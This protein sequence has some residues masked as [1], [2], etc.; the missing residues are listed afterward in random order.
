MAKI[1][2]VK[3]L[4]ILVTLGSLF[5][6]CF[7]KD[8][9]HDGL[10]DEKD[11]CPLIGAKSKNGCPVPKEMDEIHLYLDNSA[12]MGG[13][14]SESTEYK[15][16]VSDLAVTMEKEIKPISISFIADNIIFYPKDAQQFTSD[17]ATTRIADQNSSQLHLMIQK[18]VSNSKANDVSLLISDCILSFPDSAIKANPEINKTDAEGVLKNNIYSTFADLKRKDIATSIYAFQS[19]F[20][21]TYYNYQ[22][23]HVPLKS[24]LR[25]FY[26]WV[27]AQKDIL[28]LF[29]AK[30]KEISSFKPV[31]ELH[32]G[33]VDS[34]VRQYHILPQLG[35]GGH[36]K[37]IASP[38]AAGDKGLQDIELIK[39]EPLFFNAVVNLDG[40]PAYAKDLVYLKKNLQLTSPGCK[41]TFTVK[42]K[43]EV[44][45]DKIKS[46]DQR[47]SFE[48]ATH[49]IEIRV[50]E[51][52]LPGTAIQLT[53][54]LKYDTWYKEWSSTDDK[55]VSQ[56][57]H[58]TFA[59]N[60]LIDGVKQAY[61]TRNKNFISLTFNLNK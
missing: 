24:Q 46:T 41:A 52:R 55:Q 40:L 19:N 43:S 18:I 23:T 60:Y 34:A 50:N 15:T 61:E 5:S 58:Q 37:K 7:Q 3:Y 27:I 48:G 14:F 57:G 21:G 42:P 25:P 17:I 44:N 45:S 32:I 11:Q 31:Q 12:S 2:K 16:I 8:S 51:L 33:L 4:I 28:K 6:S 53:L 9:D 36:W 47:I 26:V 10:V 59:F 38:L 39:T 13:Y 22:N 29:D 54:P 1:Y 30:M 49:V 35:R 20:T 56:Q